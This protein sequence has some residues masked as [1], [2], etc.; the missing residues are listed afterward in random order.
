M[1]G[2]HNDEAE[3]GNIPGDGSTIIGGDSTIPTGGLDNFIDIREKGT[4]LADKSMLIDRI[5]SDSSFITYLFCRPRRFGKSINLTMLDAFLNIRYRNNT[6]FDGMMISEIEGMERF[7]NSFPVILLD[8][9]DLGTGDRDLL[10]RNFNDMII[11]TFDR[12]NYLASSEALTDRQKRR[13]GRVLDDE[14]VGTGDLR[15]LTECLHTHH[16][17][18]AVV[19]VDEYDAPIVN[20][21]DTDAFGLSMDL[22]RKTL[23]PL[24]KGNP[25]IEKAVLVGIL[26]V[27]KESLFSGVNNLLVSTVFDDKGFGDLFGMTSEEVRAACEEAGHPERF[28]E[29]REFYDGYR[30]GGHEIFNPYSVMNYFY[31]RMTL[32]RYWVRTGSER[33]F[34]DLISM[35]DEDVRSKL[36]TI[37]AGD[38]VTVKMDARLAFPHSGEV[39]DMDPEAVFSLLTQAG[40]FTS[41]RIDIDT[42]RVWIPNKE[43]RTLFESNIMDWMGIKDGPFNKILDALLEGKPETVVEPIMNLFHEMLN[44]NG[45]TLWS[46]YQLVLAGFLAHQDTHMVLPEHFSGDGVT[47]ISIVPRRNG[48]SAILEFKKTS[49][50]GD[51]ETDA[52]RALG[53]IRRRRY[54]LGMKG[55]SIRVYGIAVGESAVVICS[56]DGMYRA[57][58][59]P[60]RSLEKV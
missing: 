10:Q 29:I 3:K 26:Q 35:R 51:P 46:S 47:D 13:F 16:G 40:Y 11:D 9:K 36:T 20:T 30:I 56:E 25:H 42:Y 48:L 8:F 45:E 22:M 54:S 50:G 18:P 57:D 41:E 31:N 38:P 23:P 28:D 43:I 19:L 34:G 32:D 44:R 60:D 59:P 55:D 14:M 37:S 27:A 6:W 2:S 1:N 17:V 58:F 53:Q 39:G 24:L 12:F 49:G 21:L 7:R 4:Y 52:A 5:M 15:F 33:V